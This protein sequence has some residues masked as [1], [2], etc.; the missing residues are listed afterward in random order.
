MFLLLNNCTDDTIF[1]NFPKVS[2]HFPKISEDF[3]RF[4][5][6]VSKAQSH[7]NKLKC[8]WRVKTKCYQ[9][10]N[11]HIDKDKLIQT[12]HIILSICYH[13]SVYH[14]DFNIII[15][16]VTGQEITLQVYIFSNTSF[17][18]L[19]CKLKITYNTKTRKK[20]WIP[21]CSSQNQLWST[22]VLYCFF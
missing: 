2:D 18:P 21:A 8:S 9:T 1:D 19:H 17:L 7:T 4:S 13:S 3:G 15:N 20:T 16:D 5:K 11:L 6:I 14:S 10:W 22:V 12:Y